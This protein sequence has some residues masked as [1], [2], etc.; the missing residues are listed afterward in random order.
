NPAQSYERYFGLW[1]DVDLYDNQK[2]TDWQKQIYGNMGLVESRDLAIRGGSEKFNFNLN[3]ALFDQKAIMLGSNFRRDNLSVSLKSKAS[4]KIDLSFTLRYSNTEVNGGGA[5][6]QNEVS[7]ADARLRHSVGYSPIPLPGLTTD[8]TDEAL[9]SYLIDPFLAVDDNQRQKTR[10]NFNMVGSFSWKMIDNLKYR[11]DVG[12]DNRTDGD[13][14]FYGRSTYYAN[15]RPSAV[16][17]GLPAFVTNDRTQV[18]FR[19]AN[20][21]NY[22]F[23]DII[24]SED[25]EVKLLVGEEMLITNRN[26][27]TTE[28]HGFPKFFDFTQA[29]NLFSQGI[30][31]AVNN[32]Y[33]PDDKLLSFF[34][35]VNYSF[36]NRYLL[37]AT[38]RADGS[39]KFLGDNAWGYFPSAA[40]AWKISE[41]PF[42][43]NQDWIDLL[44]LRISYG[45]SG[46]NNIP[47]GQTARNFQSNN[48]TYING[49]T[50]YWAPSTVLVNPD[51]KWETT[52]TQNIG[53]DFGIFGSK[54]TGSLE[55]YKNITEDLLFRFNIPNDTGYASQ[56]RNV[57]EVQNSGVEASLNFS[58][59]EKS[60]YGLNISV[61]AS[62]NR[63]EIL[64]MGELE[65]FGENTNWASSQIGDDYLVTVGQPLGVMVG[66][67]NDGRYEVSD[68]NYDP[69]ADEYT[70]KS[71]VADNQVIGNVRPGSMKLK[72]ISGPDGIPDG[73]VD[74]N[75]QEIIGDANPDFIGGVVLSG[76]AYGFDLTAAFNFS[77]GQDVYNANKIEFS[78]ANENGQYR[79]LSTVMAD[80]VRW[81]NLDPSTGQI[82]NDPTQLEALNK[83]TTLWSPYMSRYVFSDWAVEDASFLRLNTLTI[84][85]S[86]PEKVTKKLGVSNL[87]FYTTAN[88]VFLLTNYSGPDPEV[89]TRRRTPLT[90]GVDYS[91]YPRSRQYVFGLNLNF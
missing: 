24:E 60:D 67:R 33:S 17:Q 86:L 1:Q 91:A 77:V 62:V 72:D 65:N 37:T 23:K 7:S 85:Y 50:N 14:R 35:R 13:N 30:P 79:N 10:K 56:Y 51:L 20:T 76:R 44:K 74:I 73:I 46:N 89:S 4:E 11:M 78:T 26:T 53:L 70:L 2:G 55:A 47:T 49:V 25:H 3:Y 32:F 80:G 22:D 36:K 5:N 68:F 12:L 87:R 38:Y 71:G 57:G 52:V 69:V 39:S 64:S 43:E 42:L 82:V 45:E 28:I 63:N 40:V 84:G 81:T 8:E 18:R 19:N 90:P 29:Q 58:I 48:T 59:L 83:N 15:N 66:F 6:E 34:G 16:N 41:E 54:I 88:N 27:L 75:D 31:Q 61:N 9:Q 21:L